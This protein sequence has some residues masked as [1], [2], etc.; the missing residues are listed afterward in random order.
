MTIVTFGLVLLLQ[1]VAGGLGL[2]YKTTLL[3]LSTIILG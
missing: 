3:G 2:D 1:T